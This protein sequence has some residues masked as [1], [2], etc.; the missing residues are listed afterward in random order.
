MP[1]TTNNTIEMKE[2]EKKENDMNKNI[3]FCSLCLTLSLFVFRGRVFFHHFCI[4]YT[5][6]TF[7]DCCFRCSSI[8]S[9]KSVWFRFISLCLLLYHFSVILY[10]WALLFV[11]ISATIL[12]LLL[13]CVCVDVLGFSYSGYNFS[14]VPF[15][16]VL[17]YDDDVLVTICCYC[18]WWNA[19]NRLLVRQFCFP[20]FFLSFILLRSI[21]KA[22]RE[23]ECYS[24]FCYLCAIMSIVVGC[25]LR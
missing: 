16:C 6:N 2:K 18:Y 17:L 23:R 11:L 14:L 4:V 7:A 13:A 8:H 12:L 25:L 9:R 15:N 5:L 1:Y 22:E 21:L 20:V 3:I 24:M 10:F 19:Y